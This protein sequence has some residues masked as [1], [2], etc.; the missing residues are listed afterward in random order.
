MYNKM[1][2]ALF[3]QL[4]QASGHRPAFPLMAQG[5]LPLE[6][7]CQPCIHIEPL[8]I[9]PGMSASFLVLL[10]LQARSHSK[11]SLRQQTAFCTQ[12]QRW[13]SPHQ[14]LCFAS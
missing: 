1:L 11:K 8:T 9:A 14:V 12:L 2:L 7:E 6:V 13:P 10:L 5:I 3:H 4:L